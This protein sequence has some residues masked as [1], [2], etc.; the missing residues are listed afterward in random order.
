MDEWMD[1]ILKLSYLIHEMTKN[2]A[3][4]QGGRQ[5]GRGV[6][7]LNAQPRLQLRPH[8][9]HQMNVLLKT[10]LLPLLPSRWARAA[11]EKESLRAY[12]ASYQ[13]LFTST[14]Q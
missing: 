10:L 3:I 1:D 14:R 7:Q 8:P 12:L 9:A 11:R 2:D 5:V 6:R 13:E 4:G